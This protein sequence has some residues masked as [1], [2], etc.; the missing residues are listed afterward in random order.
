M[1]AERKETKQKRTQNLDRERNPGY[2]SV[3]NQG[4]ER[5]GADARKFAGLG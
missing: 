1:K 3:S 5:T 4:K 2:L